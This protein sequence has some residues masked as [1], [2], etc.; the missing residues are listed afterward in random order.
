MGAEEHRDRMTLFINKMSVYPECTLTLLLISNQHPVQ[1]QYINGCK[2]WD[3]L[4]AYF[5]NKLVK[6]VD[7]NTYN[8]P[9][10]LAVIEKNQNGSTK[11]GSDL[12][13]T[14]HFNTSQ[15]ET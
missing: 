14:S 4:S 13:T 11:E 15:G 9:K 1:N 3:I 7:I 6:M 10:V 12:V 2:K 8:V 5:S